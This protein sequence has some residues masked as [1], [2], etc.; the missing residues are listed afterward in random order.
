MAKKFCEE[1]QLFPAI[2]VE[3]DNAEENSAIIS[4]LKKNNFFQNFGSLEFWLGITD[5]ESEGQWVFESTGLS[6]VFTSWYTGE[7]NNA[8]PGEDCAHID[9]WRSKWNDVSCNVRLGTICEM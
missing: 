1:E 5:R 8:N 4:H 9:D 3:I 6:V 2:L 7:P